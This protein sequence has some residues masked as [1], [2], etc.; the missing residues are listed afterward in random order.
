M[1]MTTIPPLRILGG[2]L[3][4]VFCLF[5]CTALAQPPM[6]AESPLLSLSEETSRSTSSLVAAESSL[7]QKL[8]SETGSPSTLYALAE[9]L[10]RENKPKESLEVYTEAAQVQKPNAEEL[11]SVAM[12][13][14]LMKMYGDAIH[15]LEIAHSFDPHDANV[16]YDLGRCFYTQDRFH[17][18]EEMYLSVL[19]LAPKSIK[20]EENLGLTLDME[21]EP[22]RAEATLRTAATWAEQEQS[23]EWPYL[24]LGAYLQ[25]HDRAAEAVPFLEKA[26]NRNPKN[27]ACHE[28]LG[29]ALADSGQTAAGIH[30]LQ[31]AAQLDSRNP[32]IH[33]ELGH[34]YRN[35]GQR[36]KAAAEFALSQSL[37]GTR[38]HE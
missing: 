28:K 7:R 30:E 10:R 4:A 31:I 19:Q 15:W 24:N 8:Q 26:T 14:A 20:A 18:A 2:L 17:E 3:A 34:A 12:D 6:Q 21:R 1:K 23:D 35:A 32:K 29:R 11:R 36:D 25:E 37:Y 27:A 16:L 33:F 13:Y 38:S 5:G 9:V 22:Q